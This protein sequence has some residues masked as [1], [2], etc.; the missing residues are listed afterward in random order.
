M[1]RQ[2]IAEHSLGYVCAQG[3]QAAA[4][5]LHAHR[6]AH[7]S[8]GMSAGKGYALQRGRRML[9]TDVACTQR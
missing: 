5:T 7:N 9:R 1:Q 2:C 3:M 6:Y 4:L 8:A